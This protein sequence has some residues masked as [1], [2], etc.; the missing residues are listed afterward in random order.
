MAAPR[1]AA[2]PWRPLRWSPIP[3]TCALPTIPSSKPPDRAALPSLDAQ[4]RPI[5][6]LTFDDGPHPRYTM[7][8]LNLLD[9]HDA[10]ATFFV[11]GLR[12]VE[13]PAVLR[14]VASRGHAIGVHTW[15]HRV[16][17]RH[18]RRGVCG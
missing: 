17:A 4:G 14:E 7:L 3:V 6:Y 12:V 15:D 10:R 13:Y 11:L 16:T 2:P 9:Q 8:I 18:E 1:A 5:L